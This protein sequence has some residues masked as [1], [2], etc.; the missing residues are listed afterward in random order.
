MTKKLKSLSEAMRAI[1]GSSLLLG[2]V[3]IVSCDNGDDDPEPEPYP[4]PGVYTFHEAILQTELTLPIEI[5]PGTP[6]TI[7]EGTDITEEMKNGLLAEAPCDDPENGAVELKD[8]NE[9]FFT[10]IGESN[11]AKAGTWS[12]NSDTTVLTLVLSVEIGT[13]NL[14]I[15]DLDIDESTDII[16]GTIGN[17]PITKALLAG[18]LSGFGL[19]EQEIQGL[20][21]TVDDNWT[22]L[23]DVDIK[24]KKET[25]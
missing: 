8:T 4:L 1:L 5:I 23:V 19:S 18:F 2:L 14:N 9:L 24:F 21:A 6:I 12:V 7:D 15:Q 17:F 25:S 3:F 10:C 11:E 16:G 20:L 22:V 13:L